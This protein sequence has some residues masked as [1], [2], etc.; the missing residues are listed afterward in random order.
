M[1]TKQRQIGDRGE[2]AAVRY[3]RLHGYRILARNYTSGHLELDIVAATLSELVFVE[4]KTRTYTPETI[5]SAPSP[6][7]AVHAQ[8]QQ[9]TRRAAFAYMADHP[10]KKHPRMDVIEI[11]LLQKRPDQ[12]PKI[13][14][15]H[16]F[17]G[18]Y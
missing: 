13:H 8:K 2:R 9:A 4:V 5:T 10:T 6:G 11:W 15:I 1:A 17:K 14:A 3:L 7:H 18:A 16:H 12:K